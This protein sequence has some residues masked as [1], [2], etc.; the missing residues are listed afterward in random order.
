MY[1]FDVLRRSDREEGVRVRDGQ[2]TTRIGCEINKDGMYGETTGTFTW[3]ARIQRGGVAGT[4]PVPGAK[5]R[6]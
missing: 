1:K 5:M 2:A 3:E 6:S 4:P